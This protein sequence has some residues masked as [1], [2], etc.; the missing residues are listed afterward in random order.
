MPSSSSRSS[1]RSVDTV[2]TFPQQL[3][4]RDTVLSFPQQLQGVIPSSASRS[5][6]RSV[7]IVLS[8]PQQL[9]VRDTVLSFPQQL[10]GCRRLSVFHA[11]L[12]RSVTDN[13]SEYALQGTGLVLYREQVLFCSGNRSCSVPGTGLA[14]SRGQTLLCAGEQACSVPG[15]KFS[16]LVIQRKLRRGSGLG[17]TKLQQS[18]MTSHS[19]TSAV[20]TKP[21]GTLFL[22]FFV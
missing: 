13:L 19:I 15:G 20:A 1:C 21:L 16:P 10:Q 6:F 4:L 18:V 3:Q 2:L 5:S 14:L 7:D 8:F 12:Q 22:R 9:Q 17:N 11:S